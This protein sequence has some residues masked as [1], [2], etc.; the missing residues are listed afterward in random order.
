MRRC[1]WWAVVAWSLY[2]RLQSRQQVRV[3]DKGAHTVGAMAPGGKAGGD[4][5][6]WT[7]LSMTVRGSVRGMPASLLCWMV[8]SVLWQ[9]GHSGD[10]HNVF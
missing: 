4:L 8:V 10:H 7:S 5:E 9:S 2:S 3:E 1:G 6:G